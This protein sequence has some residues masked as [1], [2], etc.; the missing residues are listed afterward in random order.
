MKALA[1]ADAGKGKMHKGGETGKLTEHPSMG[2][3]MG[4]KAFDDE[5]KSSHNARLEAYME[6]L[7]WRRGSCMAI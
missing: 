1:R 3:Y 7:P 2:V 6:G 5:R 4:Q